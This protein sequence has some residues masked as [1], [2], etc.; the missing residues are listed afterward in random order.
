MAEEKVQNQPTQSMDQAFADDLPKAIS[1]MATREKSIRHGSAALLHRWWARRPN[2]LARIGVYLALTET[3]NPEP[4]FLTDLSE[5]S[6]AQPLLSLAK[7][8][9]RETQWRWAWR[10]KQHDLD[11]G[12]SA[13]DEQ[14]APEM[15][16]VLDPFAGGGA[17]PAEAARLGCHAYASDLNPVAYHILQATLQYPSAYIGPDNAIPGTTSNRT[18]AG[19]I[20]ELAHWTRR[21]DIQ[22]SARISSLFRVQQDENVTV[23]QYYLWLHT[24]ECVN[25]SCQR[26]FPLR[27]C[28]PLERRNK[29]VKAL[30][31]EL[32]DGSL[33]SRITN[34]IIEPRDRRYTCPF[35]GQVQAEVDLKPKESVRLPPLL[36]VV[37]FEDGGK[38]DFALVAPS[39]T[40]A[41]APWS[42]E[43]THRLEQLLEET[44]ARPLSLPL[45][46]QTYAS[47]RQR[48]YSTFRDLFTPR[49]LLVALEYTEAIRDTCSEMEAA[50]IPV[51]RIHALCTY[52]TFFLGSLVERNSRLCSWH[53]AQRMPGTSLNSM[54]ASFTPVFAESSPFG[55]AERWLAKT[56]PAIENCAS[57]PRATEVNL[58]DASHLAYSDEF[59]DAI[60]TDPPYFDSVPYADLAAFYW[61]WESAILSEGMPSLHV[62]SSQRPLETRR[63]EAP[64]TYWQGLESA[65][66]ESYRVLKPGRTFAMLLTEKV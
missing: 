14:F 31:F 44:F 49:Q 60:V 57:M 43:H 32:T 25:S 36:A 4:T 30:L 18:W 48:G 56:L 34:M 13:S 50:R 55:M 26:I 24:T 53:F 41:F 7:S 1:E 37:V 42:D 23:P 28:V 11:K 33:L 17:I 38:K 59:F 2:V 51:D 12:L 64:D 46:E 20:A 45:P 5:I 29:Q 15:P 58:C 6:P 54:T 65:W 16:R 21:M 35:C 62:S 19:L 63:G 61:V 39:D 66:R 47:V 40:V 8:H 3:Q 27:N 22:A 10:E 9:L 52:L